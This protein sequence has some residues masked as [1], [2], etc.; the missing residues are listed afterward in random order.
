MIRDQVARFEPVE[1]S[2]R[3]IGTQMT[4]PETGFPPRCMTDGEKG[5]V[6]PA[7]IPVNDIGNDT[8]RIRR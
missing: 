5:D 6:E 1:Q 7:L 8:M 4:A 3:I 2:E